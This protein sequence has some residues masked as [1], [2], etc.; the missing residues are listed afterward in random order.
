MC[1]S[2]LVTGSGEDERGRS[3]QL[4]PLGMHAVL[5]CSFAVVQPCHG[6]AVPQCSSSVI[7]LSMVQPYMPSCKC[8]VVQMNWAV[9]RMQLCCAATEPQYSCA[10]MLLY[11]AAAMPRCCCATQHSKLGNSS[12]C[13]EG[14]AWETD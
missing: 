8:A 2:I 7:Q 11:Q 5:Q 13:G 3:K 1:C 14:F 12:S 6:A 4:L 9:V 10:V